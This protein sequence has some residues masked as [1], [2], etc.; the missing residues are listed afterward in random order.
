[1]DTLTVG[2]LPGRF[3][4]IPTISREQIEGNSPDDGGKHALFIKCFSPSIGE[5]AALWLDVPEAAASQTERAKAE[6]ER[7]RGSRTDKSAEIRDNP[8]ENSAEETSARK[9]AENSAEIRA[10]I[11]PLRKEL[12][13]QALTRLATASASLSEQGEGSDSES[14]DALYYPGSLLY[15]MYPP[16]EDQSAEAKERHE[17]AEAIDTF[18][19]YADDD[20]R[21]GF[22]SLY[23]GGLE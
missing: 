17:L 19:E 14:I 2:G 9:C 3:P 21:D 4:L 23:R 8:Q 16:L 10:D 7:K 22:I 12:T 5:C 1:M 18:L 6:A 15:A 13:A 20:E 11:E